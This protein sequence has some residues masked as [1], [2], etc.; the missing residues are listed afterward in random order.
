MAH[1]QCQVLVVPYAELSKRANLLVEL[2]QRAT[3]AR[4]QPTALMQ[5]L[6][7]PAPTAKSPFKKAGT[8]TPPM[9]AFASK[10]PA[11]P[12]VVR[13]ESSPAVIPAH[14]PSVSF[15]PSTP[16]PAAP[17]KEAMA[18]ATSSAGPVGLS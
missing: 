16:A 5:L 18:G 7:P 14:A 8:A 6:Q 13:G 12:P 11:P 1:T 17:P 3:V 15:A 10:P 2:R 4:T 9:A